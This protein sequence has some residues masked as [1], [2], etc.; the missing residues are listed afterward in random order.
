MTE[1]QIPNFG[2][3]LAPFIVQVGP[4]LRPRFLALLERGA[5]DRYRYWAE[6]LPEHADGLLACAAREDEIADR[7]EAAFSVGADD[8][9]VLEAPLPGARATYLEVFDG[10]SNWDQLRIQAN[11]ERQG[12]NAW[13]STAATVT[14]PSVLEQLAACSALEESSADFLDALIA[15][16]G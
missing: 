6:Q 15:T 4:E 5:A 16:H 14:D 7:I 3:L 10:R 13:R 12:A 11:A 1:T 9:P 8:L 2:A